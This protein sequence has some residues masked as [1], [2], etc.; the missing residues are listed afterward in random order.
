[1]ASRRLLPNLFVV[2]VL[3]VIAALAFTF[4]KDMDGPEVEVKPEN[5]RV[6]AQTQLEVVV[7]D[8]SGIREL[9]V[10]V[11]KNNNFTSFF[12]KHYDG[13][14][15]RVHETLNVKDAKLTEGLFELEV[16][17]TDASLAGFGSGNTRTELVEMRYDPN[18]PR[19]S[20][21]TRPANVW[22]GGAGAVRFSVDEEVTQ[23]GVDIG[24]YFVPAAL[25]A[26][27]TWVCVYPFPF[28]MS[29]P[30]FKNS[31][32]LTATDLAGNV[33]RTRFT[34]LAYE[35]RF[36]DDKL[37]LT[38]SF[39]EE[40]MSKLRHLA[41]DCTGPLQC[42]LT[43]N[44]EVRGQNVVRIREL[45]LSS[46]KGKLWDGNFV[47]MP[48][49]ARRAGYADH[50]VLYYNGEPVAEATHLGLDLASTRA[51]EVPAAN[52]GVVL[53]AGELGI[54][55]N[56]VVVDHGL[57]VMTLYSHLSRIGVQQGQAVKKGDVLG[58]TGTTGLAFGD[59]LHFGVVVGGF[60]VTPIEWIDSK[61]LENLTRRITQDE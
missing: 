44:G 35:R 24:G 2:F 30:D 14:Q 3:G 5:R 48:R 55:G 11:R 58:N 6:G 39:L 9:N 38:D 61:W 10:G 13:D 43:I 41:P 45:G 25:Q 27:G 34:V 31:I 7:T 59:H 29:A 4:L 54:Y 21:K 42:Y 19:I 15:T 56:V 46:A 57:G 16:R 28:N 17:A 20:V 50:R 26:D 22:R 53:Y 47:T 49:A 23:A 33:T 8:P 18:P 40:A 52:N 36:R 1:M 12:R 60:E 32:S 37:T 51:A